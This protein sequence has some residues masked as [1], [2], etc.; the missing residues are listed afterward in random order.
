MAAPAPSSSRVGARLSRSASAVRVFCTLSLA[1]PGLQRGCQAFADEP[2]PPATR[3]LFFPSGPG[4]G[5]HAVALGGIWQ[6]APQLAANWRWGLPLGFSVGASLQTVVLRN[7]LDVGASW[8]TTFGP[9]FVGA[10]MKFGAWI[11]FL[12]GFGFDSM[13]WGA[14]WE[15]G[16]Q[17]G[18]PVAHDA[19]L[20]LVLQGYFDIYEAARLGSLVFVPSHRT[21]YL[22]L[23]ASLIVELA[24]E[25][26][27]IYFG[28][29]IF[30]TSPNYPAWINFSYVDPNKYVYPSVLA[31]YEF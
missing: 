6:V 3:L 19:W 1:V 23:G 2:A 25:H 31:G 28:G 14:V 15:P 10:S 26:G 22:G 4:E 8:F 7:Q 12:N 24:A 21:L 29:G 11:G 30:H 20:T 9:F 18:L 17:A 5:R 13:A 27:V 16:L